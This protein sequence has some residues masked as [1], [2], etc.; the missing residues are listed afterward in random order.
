[1]NRHVRD[2]LKTLCQWLIPTYLLCLS[3]FFSIAAL[4][5][6]MFTVADSIGLTRLVDPAKTSLS[7]S[8]GEVKRSPDGNYFF[9][10]TEQGNL[11]TDTLQYELL[12][13]DVEEVLL[14]VS[15]DSRD[16]TLS[17][18]VL[19]SFESTPFGSSARRSGGIGQARWLPDS[20][21][22]AFVGERI[23]VPAQVYTVDIQSG[24]LRQLTTH[25]T[26]VLRFAVSSEADR[27][28]YVARDELPDWQDRNLKGY[29]V[30]SEHVR[31]LVSL[32]PNIYTDAAEAFYVQ[33]LSEYGSAPRKVH[34][35]S[36]K[37]DGHGE[38]WPSSTG[39]WVIALSYAPDIPATWLADYEVLRRIGDAK[40]K[41]AKSPVFTEKYSLVRRF[42]LIDTMNGTVQDI[43][44]AP[45]SWGRHDAHWSHDERS[46]I[47]ANT[48]LP[49]A[50]VDPD[51]MTL[52]RRTASVVE[53]ELE[54]RRVKPIDYFTVHAGG[55]Q[56]VRTNQVDDGLLRVN[57]RLPG[58][59]A[60]HTA[61]YRRKHPGNWVRVDL[62]AGSIDRER[63]SLSIVQDMNTPPDLLATDRVTNQSRV[64]TNF[65]PQ[66]ENRPIG[67]M[68]KI[69][70][71]D[72][73]GRLW[74]GGLI[75][76]P[77]YG[78]N[79]KYPLV[80]QTYGFSDDEFVVDGPHG[81]TSAYAARPLASLGIMVLQMGLRPKEHRFELGDPME[82]PNYVAGFEGAV[83]HLD[84]RGIIDPDRVGL[85]GFSRTGL[86]VSYAVAFSEIQ[87][88]A[89]TIADSTSAGYLKHIFSYGHPFPGMI[90]DEWLIGAPFWGDD[91]QI[92]L[93]KS[94]NLNAH[95]V[96]TPLRFEQ[97][98]IYI[99]PYW[100]MFALM[101]RN[102]RAVEMIHIPLAVH[103][104][105]RPLAR[106]TSQQGNVDWFAFWLNDYEDPNP[107]KADQYERW[108]ELRVRY[109][110]TIQAGRAAMPVDF[111]A[112]NMRV[113]QE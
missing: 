39:R 23:G 104:V 42:V 80:I 97:Y 107:S 95:R 113:K 70:W 84:E 66:L 5:S 18:R 85:I 1:M 44:R 69:E 65:N 75:Y 26:H 34:S 52:R 17:P 55:G 29:A 20:K 59:G 103:V 35:A 72:K 43:I 99:N 73:N 91:R 90:G 57:F 67:Y 112:A 36:G 11:R 77:D 28:V 37:L 68:R 93:E 10:V 111:P 105:Q 108:R 102:G 71:T 27:L 100:D 88:A 48:H 83:K 15:S 46:V 58:D 50:D 94:P 61:Y 16:G 38:L 98:G 9:I 8:V 101:R 12:L 63:L 78:S 81:I 89:A 60:E 40:K 56:I 22:I 25:A 53:F 96:Y 54:S 21:R 7:G 14:F 13:F 110:E 62:E 32:E 2:W 64:V 30:G 49:L 82:G 45:V 4:G 51:E 79:R 6:E 33:D 47:L 31:H 74:E 41:G 109:H 106:Y 86:H 19:V 3:P 87:F 24:E 92:W 76:P